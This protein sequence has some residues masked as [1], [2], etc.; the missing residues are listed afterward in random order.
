VPLALRAA[1]DGTPFR[2]F[3][4]DYPTADGTC[5]RDYVHVADL[6]DAH[7]LALERLPDLPPAL[8]LGT[9]TGDSVL[10]VLDTVEQVTGRALR[11]V[12]A[13]RRPGDSPLLVAANDQ[14]RRT[15]GWSPRRS[16]SDAVWDAWEWMR[17]HPRGYA[18]D[19][20]R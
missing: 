16:L 1:A 6:A 10:A 14:A 3:G 8:N 13:P 20:A 9:G 18:E 11:R 7:I 17:T 2:I 5:V 15:L 19:P 4:N 12:A